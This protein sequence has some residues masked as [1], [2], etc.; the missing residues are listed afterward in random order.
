MVAVQLRAMR[1]VKQQLAGS[2]LRVPFTGDTLLSPAA[3]SII[4][5]DFALDLTDIWNTVYYI[6]GIAGLWY[7]S[8]EVNAGQPRTC[9]F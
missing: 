9:S 3:N 8:G 6:I 5:N 2:G 4:D 7:T 1:F